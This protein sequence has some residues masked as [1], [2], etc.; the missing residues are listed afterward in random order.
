MKNRRKADTS[1]S[2]VN[3]DIHVD[4]KR[5]KGNSTANIALKEPCLLT[6]AFEDCCE[7]E[8]S[9]SNSAESIEEHKD[10]ARKRSTVYLGE[11]TE[12]KS[13]DGAENDIKIETKGAKKVLVKTMSHDS[14]AVS[15]LKNKNGVFLYI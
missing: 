4:T 14:F 11:V 5:E 1:T 2:S 3:K 8:E 12:R 6:K 13:L 9:G 7:K 15:H 10:E